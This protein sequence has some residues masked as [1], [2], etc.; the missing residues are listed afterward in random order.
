MTVI[1]RRTVTEF[2]AFL[3]NSTK[4]NAN[5]IG[6]WFTKRGIVTLPDRLDIALEAQVSD[7]VKAKIRRCF[8]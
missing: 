2:A 5:T 1:D 4:A 7:D 8:A 6:A 3:R